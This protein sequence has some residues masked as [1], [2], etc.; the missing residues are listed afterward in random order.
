M[1][2]RREMLEH[3]IGN[4]P[5][6]RDRSDNEPALDMLVRQQRSRARGLDVGDRMALDCLVALTE[7]CLEVMNS[8]TAT[9]STIDD[10]NGIHFMED[11]ATGTFAMAYDKVVEVWDL[12]WFN[13]YARDMS[14][15]VNGVITTKDELFVAMVL[16]KVMK[17]EV[18]STV[19]TAS[20][21][22]IT[23]LALYA[24]AGLHAVL[25]SIGEERLN[26]LLQGNREQLEEL[27][28]R[29]ATCIFVQRILKRDDLLKLF[30]EESAAMYDVQL[31]L[32]KGDKEI[33]KHNVWVLETSLGLHEDD[34]EETAETNG[35]TD[36]DYSTLPDAL[37]GSNRSPHRKH[38][39]VD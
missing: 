33:A 2:P 8:D 26:E 18:A 11:F 19:V 7:A 14:G 16:T 22:P 25:A 28:F 4:F 23:Q 6:G 31:Y 12:P 36:I 3:L 27:V 13:S 10:L 38:V 5:C 1:D 15:R 9:K 30:R 37:D 39:L 20:G 24:A 29:P 35:N 17:G 34:P 21:L 32:V